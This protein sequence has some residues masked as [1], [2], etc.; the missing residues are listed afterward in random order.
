[1]ALIFMG[2][3]SL[4]EKENIN[5]LKSK[6]ILWYKDL[7]QSKNKKTAFPTEIIREDFTEK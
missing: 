2:F 4:W 1:M 6:D 5:I 3:M 7:L